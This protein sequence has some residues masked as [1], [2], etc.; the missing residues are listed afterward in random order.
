MQLTLIQS[1]KNCHEQSLSR[2]TSSPCALSCVAE[3]KKKTHTH[4][5]LIWLFNLSFELLHLLEWFYLWI[6][7]DLLYLDFLMIHIKCYFWWWKIAQIHL[8]FQMEIIKHISTHSIECLLAS[9][10][11]ILDKLEE[12]QAWSQYFWFL[13]QGHFQNNESSLWIWSLSGSL[14]GLILK[15]LLY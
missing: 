4:T 8:A 5:D 7:D 6:L 13:P 3:K 2:A 12:P 14:W 9:F 10:W 11:R 1:S 15:F